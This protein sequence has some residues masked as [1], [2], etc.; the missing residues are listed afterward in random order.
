MLT[1]LKIENIAIIELADISFSDGF[2]VMT[3]ETGAG[4]SIIIDSINAVTGE[5]TSKELIRTGAQSGKVTAVFENVSKKVMSKLEEMGIDSEDTVILSRNIKKDGKNICTVNGT[6]VTVSM[7]K[8][9][10][11]ELINIHGQHDSQSLLQS[12]MHCGFIDSFGDLNELLGKY[13]Q[14]YDELCEITSQIRSLDMDEQQKARRID[15]LTF[16]INELEDADITIGE[17]EELKERRSFLKNAQKIIDALNTA[18]SYLYSDG[19]GCDSVSNA[20]Y[21]VE[22]ILSFYDGASSVAQRLNDAKYELEDCCEEIRS[23]IASADSDPAELDSVE[24]RLD[25]LHRLS[26][27]YG[28]DEEEMLAFLQSAK[29][30][31]ETITLSEERTEKL[32]AE[33]ELALKKTKALA[34]E[35]SQ[36][37]IEAGER[38]AAKICSELEFL[39]MPNI[40]F[41]VR[42][43]EKPLSPDG[44]DDIEFL[45]S[46]NV[47][48]EPKP[49][50]KIAS[51]GELSR[52]MLA[53]KNSLAQKDGTDTMI[54]DEIDTGVSGAAA[55]KIAEKLFEV[56][57]GRQV[58]CVTH[59][60]QIA[61][62][63]DCHKL[64]SKYVDGGK[65]FTRVDSLDY[66]QR[67][68]ELARIMGA[69]DNESAFIK[70][71]EELLTSAGVTR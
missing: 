43:G 11:G 22:G 40:T 38:L 67:A 7:L 61:A 5:R 64:I 62:F 4:K 20:T 29:A 33:K 21:E 26:S 45:I 63:A 59:L 34:V 10:G 49:L 18:Y 50:A 31:L 65:T 53:I 69:G 66:D 28:A 47:G 1:R 37:R 3:G 14:S 24:E 56:S 2:N 51:G 8:N 15:M 23:L 68:Q 32:K 70:S 13:S 48:E 6:P 42:R 36:K 58:I 35:L 44:C 57:R 54:F 12:E 55:R 30:E 52:I 39:N 27:K 16:Q 19:A 9:I 60:A 17:T 71:A 25:L 41:E 46:A